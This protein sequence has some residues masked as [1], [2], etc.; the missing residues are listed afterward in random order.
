MGDKGIMGSPGKS[1]KQGIMGSAGLKGETGN[2]ASF[3]CS[4]SGNPEPAIV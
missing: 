4:D 3:Q 1:G 2:E